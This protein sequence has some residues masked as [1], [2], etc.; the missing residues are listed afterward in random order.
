MPEALNILISVGIGVALRFAI[1]LGATI[2]IVWWLRRL[3]ARWQ[4]ESQSRPVQVVGE[5]SRA[6]RCWE[7]RNCP[8]ERRANCP[9]YARPDIPCWQVF[10]SADGSLKTA[11]LTCSV[12]R[13]APVPRLAWIEEEAR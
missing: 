11:C 13:N 9:A 7:T 8:P 3:D 10:R 6:P 1:P 2:A 12:F 5:W 4:S